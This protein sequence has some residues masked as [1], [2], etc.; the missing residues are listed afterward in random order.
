MGA[1]ICPADSF[2]GGGS[3]SAAPT[4]CG[5]HMSS[6]AGAATFNQCTVDPG[7][8]WDGSVIAAVPCWADH[9]CP[10]G[11][12]STVP[13]PCT[14]NMTSA[15]GSSAYTDCGAPPGC[16]RLH[17]LACHC[18]CAVIVAC[19]SQPSICMHSSQG[20]PLIPIIPVECGC[21]VQCLFLDSTWSM[22]LLCCAHETTGGLLRQRDCLY[23]HVGARGA[24]HTCLSPRLCTHERLV[25]SRTSTGCRCPGMNRT[26]APE[27]CNETT[28]SLPGGSSASACSECLCAGAAA[29]HMI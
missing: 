7:Y 23:F 28:V 10:G 1:V 26:A 2:C 18:T 22:K 29:C 19:S 14:G 8:V 5:P 13:T 25:P 21:C 9:F 20:L 3:R 11:S 4:P 6:V 16:T 12:Q 17:C 27:A 15:A 24:L